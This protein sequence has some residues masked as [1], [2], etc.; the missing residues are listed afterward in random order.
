M[1]AERESMDAC[2]GDGIYSDEFSWAYHT[3]GYSRYDYSR[4]DGYSADLDDEG[5]VKRLKSDNAFTTESAQLQ[6]VHEVLRR[7]KF[8][9]GNGGASL[10][11]LTGLPA[12]RFVEGGNGEPSMAG[13]HF[14]SVPLVLGNFGDETSRRGIFEAVKS[15]LSMGCVYS[16]NASNLLLEGPDNFVCKLYPITI[17]KL[18]PGWIEA[19]ER[20]IS[21]V[22]K[23]FDWPALA[24]P[25]APVVVRRYRYD[26]H[27]DLLGPPDRLEIKAGQKL[28]LT[29]PKDGLMIAEI[30]GPR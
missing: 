2:G 23:T 7:G 17:R 14:S 13:A 24:E 15:C 18:G 10:R 29:V 27:G 20:L 5:R 22:S 3:R 19:K 25:V 11:S 4:W 21:T 26:S 28:S 9:L 8:F 1:R 6:I 16:P 12:A 30:A